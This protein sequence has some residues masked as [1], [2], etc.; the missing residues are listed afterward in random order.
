MAASW[1]EQAGEAVAPA[2]RDD[3]DIKELSRVDR[4]KA[5]DLL[6][7]R[8]R[9]RLYYHALYITKDS[10]ASLDVAQEVFV[11]A[12]HEPRIFAT[13][14]HSRAWLF[15]VC[16]NRCYNLVRDRQRRSQILDRIGREEGMGTGT[17]QA[18]DNL[19]EQEQSSTMGRV[20]DR[21]SPEHRTILVLRYFNDLSY[22]EIA[23]VLKVKIGTVM[24][25]LSRAKVRLHDLLSEEEGV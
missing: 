20:L 22:Q 2:P 18:I 14:F 13:G 5:F 9:K 17:H 24:S 6:V 19:L 4:S 10:E 21:L 12:F 1:E 15:R 8:Y 3:A 23:E 16:T 7:Q 11:K 25:R